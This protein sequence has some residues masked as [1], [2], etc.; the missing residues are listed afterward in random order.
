MLFVHHFEDLLVDLFRG[1]NL[2]HPFDQAGDIR[3]A[4][5]SSASFYQKVTEVASPLARF[6]N[7][8]P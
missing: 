6:T 3:A 1:Q 7:Q 8:C 2:R 4:F 5:S